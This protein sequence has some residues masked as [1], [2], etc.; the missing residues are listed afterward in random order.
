MR[1]HEDGAIIAPSPSTSIHRKARNDYRHTIRLGYRLLAHGTAT[2]LT[3]EKGLRDA[4]AD[5]RH[6][7]ACCDARA[8]T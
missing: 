6:R 2:L 3:P 4:H 5:P 8:V 1:R 7:S